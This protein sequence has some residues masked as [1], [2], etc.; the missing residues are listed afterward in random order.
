VVELRATT[1][2]E[3]VAML[4][5]RIGRARVE[6]E[7]EAARSVVGL[8]FGLPIA[9]TAMAA[10]LRSRPPTGRSGGSWRG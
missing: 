4:V 6:R 5:T 9:I 7:P 1:D 2:D 3:L 10:L 8:A